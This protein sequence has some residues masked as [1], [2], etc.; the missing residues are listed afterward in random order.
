MTEPD[1]AREYYEA[2]AALRCLWLAERHDG[3]T[4]AE[5]L[6]RTGRRRGI[7]A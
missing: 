7:F 6:T 3:E 1:P 5:W 2:I 4:A